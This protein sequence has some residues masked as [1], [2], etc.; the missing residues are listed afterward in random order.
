MDIQGLVNHNH[1]PHD[2]R[3]FSSLSPPY[4][5]GSESAR[6]QFPGDSVMLQPSSY[7]S[8]PLRDRDEI[9]SQQQLHNSADRTTSPSVKRYLT[10]GSS[11]I[12]N[13][14]PAKRRNGDVL[15]GENGKRF[16]IRRRALQACER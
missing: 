8:L 2:D 6:S 15:N 5:S 11:R 3:P 4:H 16:P 14:P 13:G 9:Y 12:L 7:H 10:D 1:S